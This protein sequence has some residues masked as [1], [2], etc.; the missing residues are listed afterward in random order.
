[1]SLLE[2]GRGRCDTPGGKGD[3]KTKQK[4]LRM[5]AW[6]PRNA[7]SHQE[8]EEQGADSSPRASR[9]SVPADIFILNQLY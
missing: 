1:M 7:T 5:L 8:L 2:R 9:G 3:V 4:E 6:S